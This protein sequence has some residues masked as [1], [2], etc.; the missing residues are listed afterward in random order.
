M[1]HVKVS[2][3]KG[4]N[5][6]SVVGKTDKFMYVIFRDSKTGEKKEKI[7]GKCRNIKAHPIHADVQSTY[8]L[9]ATIFEFDLEKNN[10]ASS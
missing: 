3:L 10:V 6:L 9:F 1:K 7:V 5:G 4:T 2:F 8:N